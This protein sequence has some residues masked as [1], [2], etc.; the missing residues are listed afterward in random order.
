[1]SPLVSGDKVDVLLRRNGK[2]PVWSKGGEIVRREDK[3][4][5]LVK[6]NNGQVAQC[7]RRQIRECDNRETIEAV[8]FDPAIEK[9]IRLERVIKDSDELVP[10]N[11]KNLYED[12][13]EEDVTETMEK[14][15]SHD[16][17]ESVEEQE[18]KRV[19]ELIKEE[20][21]MI[22]PTREDLSL[23]HI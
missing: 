4:R 20:T 2:N 22:K 6:L 5:Y 16:L 17:E 11:I 21:S 1:M 13:Q 12:M 3:V 7:H 9:D 15:L 8:R 19:R 14:I 18:R 23:I 10:K